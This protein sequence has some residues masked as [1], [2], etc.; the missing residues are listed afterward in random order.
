VLN[1][2]LVDH[3]SDARHGQ[4]HLADALRPL[5]LRPLLSAQ[6]PAHNGEAI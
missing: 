3:G 2:A 5:H 6:F 4:R 1:A